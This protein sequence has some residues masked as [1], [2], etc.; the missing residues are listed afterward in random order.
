MSSK[1]TWRVHV[2][3]RVAK[4]IASF[5]IVE[6]ERIKSMLRDFEVDPWSGDITKIRGEKNQW[7][8]R[9]GNYRI[10]YYIHQQIK[11]VEVTEIERRTSA[12]Y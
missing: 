6:Q 12:T 3:K 4:S 11:L 5:P 7:R 2:P 8:K 10:F 9:I 1:N